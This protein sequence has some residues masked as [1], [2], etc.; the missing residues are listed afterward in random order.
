ML[1]QLYKTSETTLIIYYISITLM[2]PKK[3]KIKQKQ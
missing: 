3:E 2:I 1:F